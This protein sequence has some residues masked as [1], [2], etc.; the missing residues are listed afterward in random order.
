MTIDEM[1]LK[2]SVLKERLAEEIFYVDV[3]FEDKIT[4]RLRSEISEWLGYQLT[5]EKSEATVVLSVKSDLDD[6]LE[7]YEIRE[8]E[9]IGASSVGLLYGFYAYLRLKLTGAKLSEKSAPNQALRMINHWDQVDG[10]IERGYAGESIFFGRFGSN[11]NTD[12]GSFAVKDIGTDIFRNDFTRLEMYARFLASIGINAISLNNVNVRALGTNLIISPYIEKVGEIARIFATFGLKTFLAINWAAPKLIGG[13]ET[14]DPLDEKVSSWWQQ[15]I[16]HIYNV[17]P[18]FGGFVV[19]ADSEGEPGP[20]QYGRNHADGANML[21]KPF[22]K[23]GGLVIWRTFVYNSQTDWRNRKNDRAKA[24]YENFM[25]LDG[26]FADNVILQI[27]FGPIDFGVREPLMPLF[28]ALKKTNQ[29]MEFQITAEYLGHQIDLNYVLPQW[30]EM[31][32]FDNYGQPKNTIKVNSPIATN[33]GFVAIGNV[34]MDENWCGNKLAQANF[35]GFGRMGWNNDLTA[36]KILQ[37]WIALTF[38]EVKEEVRKEIFELLIDSNRTYELYNAPLGVGSMMVPHYHYGPSVN[39]YEYDRW[40]AYHF[41]DRNGLGIDRTSATGTGYVSLYAPEVAKIFEDKS[42]T[43]DEILLFFHY[44][45][46]GQLLK[47]GKTLIQ[48]IYDQH[49]EGFERVESYL[50]SWQTLIGEIDELTYNNVLERLKLQLE[51]A[52]N[53]RDQVNTYFY[54]MSGIPDEIGREIYR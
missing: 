4:L 22:E 2:S 26:D 46:Y 19:K 13:L 3:T 38:P 25:P 31:I 44:V 34:G 7:A 12:T 36:A 23:Y 8:N 37:E 17:I 27:K 33:S 11:D 14:S 30:L 41:A 10:T 1:W 47:N 20:Y 43:P 39:G 32:H 40:G 6:N 48:T 28:G 21:A 45:E 54:R 29:L 15:T 50:K 24:A 49:F 5:G 51:N 42:Q 35:Y 16:D 9:I 53:W 52:K 18:D